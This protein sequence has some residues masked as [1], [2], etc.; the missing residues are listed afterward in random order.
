MM[1]V[2]NLDRLSLPPCSRDPARE[3][4]R[5]VDALI[6]DFGAER[7]VAFGSCTRGESTRHSD[8]DLCVIYDQE[9]I[10]PVQ[11]PRLADRCVSRVNPLLSTDLFVVP[12]ERWEREKSKPWGLW[13]EIVEGGVDLHEG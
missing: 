8:V 4:A 11:A 5:V 9:R 6:K 1:K 3:L 7:V 2:I 13:R 10:P 12:M